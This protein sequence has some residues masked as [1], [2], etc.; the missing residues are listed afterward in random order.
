MGDFIDAIS[1]NSSGKPLKIVL[2]EMEE[3]NMMQ[4]D[5]GKGGETK[6]KRKRSRFGFFFILV[7]RCSV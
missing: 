4:K 2:R 6:A 7:Q 5:P 3:R 1:R